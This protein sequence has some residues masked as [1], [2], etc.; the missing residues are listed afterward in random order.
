[1]WCEDAWLHDLVYSRQP[2]HLLEEGPIS[3]VPEWRA[4]GLRFFAIGRNDVRLMIYWQTYEAARIRSGTDRDP[5]RARE[6][7]ETEFEYP[8]GKSYA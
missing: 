7:G 3:D 2:F 5:T 6:S 4:E 8:L 1:V